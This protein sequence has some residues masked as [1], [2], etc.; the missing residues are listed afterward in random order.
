MF[1]KEGRNL[2]KDFGE[3]DGTLFVKAEWEGFGEQMP[4]ARSET[5]MTKAQ[6]EKNRNYYTK[7]E[8]YNLLQESS[9]LDQNDP[10]NELV[11]KA[12][13]T[14]KNDYLDRLLA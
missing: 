12:L 11:I 7:Q 3:L 10:R 4:P 9:R 2:G 6:G 14:M 1:I 13:K 8:Q 5:I